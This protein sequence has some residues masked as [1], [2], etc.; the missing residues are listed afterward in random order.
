MDEVACMSFLPA[1]VCSEYEARPDLDPCAASHGREMDRGPEPRA[2]L[3]VVS[4]CAAP[5]VVVESDSNYALYV[6][7]DLP[8]PA[9]TALRAFLERARAR[10]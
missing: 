1:W 5:F 3:P 10:L 4:R 8:E 2:T 9:A 6:R 7:D